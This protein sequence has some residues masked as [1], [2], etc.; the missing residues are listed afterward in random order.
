M[1]R[2][3][4]ILKNLPA[5]QPP[6]TLKADVLKRIECLTESEKTPRRQLITSGVTLI[7]ASIAIFVILN[8]SFPV[9]LN[10]FTKQTQEKG[11]QTLEQAQTALFNFDLSNLFNTNNKTEVE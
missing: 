2:I 3:K 1:D 10:V 9:S 8:S 5:P 4:Q 6:A 11:S 7:A